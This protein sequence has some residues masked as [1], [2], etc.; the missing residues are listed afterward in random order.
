MKKTVVVVLVA[1]TAAFGVSGCAKKKPDVP[2][3]HCL[4]PGL[5]SHDK[6]GNNLLCGR[7]PQ[8]WIKVSGTEVN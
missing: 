1:L 3:H 8:V 7:D 5:T 2:G 6:D 4:A